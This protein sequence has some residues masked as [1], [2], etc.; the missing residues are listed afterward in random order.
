M[1]NGL[2]TL[3]SNLLS[4]H[5]AFGWYELSGKSDSKTPTELNHLTFL[6]SHL[7]I[8]PSVVGCDVVLAQ[9]FRQTHDA[10]SR[11]FS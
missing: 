10:G 6:G 1:H 11:F 8:F 7:T 9:V 2:W 3:P 5:A 4:Y